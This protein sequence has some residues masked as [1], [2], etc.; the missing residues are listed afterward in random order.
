MTLEGIF[1]DVKMGDLILMSN[2]LENMHVSGFV[3]KVDDRTV[4][5]SHESPYGNT[6]IFSA[7]RRGGLGITKGDRTYDLDGFFEYWILAE[8]KSRGE[9]K[10]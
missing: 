10:W 8:G 4:R 3:V 9:E 1:N 7:V 6:G 5:L 2:P